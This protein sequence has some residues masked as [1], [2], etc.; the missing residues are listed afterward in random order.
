MTQSGGSVLWRRGSWWARV[1]YRD[2]TGVRR[3]LMRKTR[4]KAAATKLIPKLLAELT[5]PPEAP[6]FHGLLLAYQEQIAVA[7]EYHGG[8]QIRGL[9][10]WQSVQGYCST[11]TNLVA[12]VP[13][14]S[15]TVPA[16]REI[17]SAL[18][19]GQNKRGGARSLANINRILATLRSAFAFAIECG[20]LEVNPFSKVPRRRGQAV[21]TTRLEQPRDRVCSPAEE[22]RILELC[23]G[24]RAHLRMKLVLL[25]ETG[26]REGETSRLVGGDVSFEKR[27][28]T[29]RL[30]KTDRPRVV[31]ITDRLALELRAAGVDALADDAP[32]IP[33]PDN[34]LAWQW[35]RKKAGCPDLQLRDLR[36][37]AGMRMLA[38]GVDPM[39][40]A[41]ILGHTSPETTF[42][43]YTTLDPHTLSETVK[44]MRE[45]KRRVPKKNAAA[46]QVSSSVN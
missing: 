8:I 27:T 38:R 25:I 5:S 39:T 29:V 20:W 2:A 30:T 14:S 15:F 9:R 7:P 31:P 6:R 22:L 35:V 16:L 34:K 40:V 13:L 28:I 12:D 46:V 42:R 33:N 21:I 3:E 43:W 1:Q 37:T 18:A 23:T 17:Q 19:I 10:S 4:T 32:V 24:E 44:K 41:K 26:M 36:T 11:L 45:R